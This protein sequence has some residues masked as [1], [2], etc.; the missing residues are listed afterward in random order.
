MNVNSFIKRNREAAWAIGILL[1]GYNSLINQE[2]IWVKRGKYTNKWF[3]DPF[4]LDYNSEIIN[5]L[6]E[7]YDYSINRGRIAKIS[8]DRNNYTIISCTILLDLQTHLSFPVIYRQG[9]IVYVCPENYESGSFNKYIYNTKE[10]KLVFHKKICDGKLTDTIIYEIKGEYYLFTTYH[11]N[12]N[13]KDLII[14]KSNHFDGPYIHYQTLHFDENIARNA[15][16]F[17]KYKDSIYRPAQESNVSYGHGLSIQLLEMDNGNFVFKEV[18]RF[19]SPNWKYP[20]GIHTYN[21]YNGMGII[22]VKGYRNP[23]VGIPFELAHKIKRTIG[24]K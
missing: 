15:G 11:P 8:I 9:E 21:E 17:F 20:N 1:D 12:A 18:K 3:A 14:L 5:V 19:H 23:L 13:G 22:D 2:I 7:E 4:I 16:F 10:D 6:V 24:L